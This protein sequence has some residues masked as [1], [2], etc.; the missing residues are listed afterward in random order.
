MKFSFFEGQPV[1]LIM[2]MVPITKKWCHNKPW[3]VFDPFDESIMIWI[4]VKIYR[5][6]DGM[7]EPISEQL[8]LWFLPW[9]EPFPQ[10]RRNL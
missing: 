2:I 1:I 5:I 7:S 4:K 3:L 9:S 8:R 6:T 10:V